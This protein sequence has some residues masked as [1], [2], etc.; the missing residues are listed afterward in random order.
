MS[1]LTEQQLAFFREE[2][3]LL[4]DDAIH[5]AVLQ[6][7]RAE[8]DGNIDAFASAALAD[9]RLSNAH[10][11]EPFERRLHALALELDDPAPCWTWAAAS[12]ARRACSGS[13]PVRRFST[14]SSP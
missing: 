9:G 13:T 7:F 6:P 12:S 3:Y 14:S 10:A 4:V 5:P 11:E 8:L 2:G 1:G